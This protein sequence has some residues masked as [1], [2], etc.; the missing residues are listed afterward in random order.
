MFFFKS[1]KVTP[2]ITKITDL[3]GV[4]VYLAEGTEKAVLIDSG[5]GIGD[6]FE[7]VHTLTEKPLSVILT[8]GHC[9]HAGGAARFDEV[10]LNEKDWYLASYHASVENK[11]GYAKFIMGEA[12]DQVC[13]ED[14]CPE[15]TKGYLPLTD[16]QIFDL[17][18]LTLKMVTVP[19]HTAGMTC[20]LFK[21]ERS[22][23]FGDACNPNVFLWDE[24]SS[25]VEEYLESLKAL[26]Q[27]ED[28]YETV[29]L[30]HGDTVIDKAVLD[31][32]I[33]ICEEILNGQAD[34]C[35]YEFM[36]KNLLLAKKVNEQQA[37]MDGG[38]GNIVY[39]PDKIRRAC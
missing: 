32:N 3:T 25:S 16:G 17:G 18:G 30:S 37:R 14:I 12:Y 36:G 2:S 19:G 7:Y 6:L 28:L 27:I 13:E 26:K 29:Y 22:I 8:H 33:K 35:I 23:L 9:D 4:F 20:I 38:L 39:N 1:E 21:E 31:G 24:E 10:Y 15:R 34:D 11:T 5:T